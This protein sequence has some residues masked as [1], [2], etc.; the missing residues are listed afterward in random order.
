MITRKN[1]ETYVLDYLEGT[2]SEDL[3]KAFENFL[4]Q[5]PD[6]REEIESLC[7]MPSITPQQESFPG[8]HRLKASTIKGLTYTEELIIAEL[9]N[10]AT[11]E[12]RQELKYIINN[13]PQIKNL[14]LEYQHTKL[15]PPDITYPYK[16]YLKHKVISLPVIIKNAV[17]YAALVILLIAIT[18][19][20]RHP[21]RQI[22][23]SL[24]LRPGIEQTFLLT[25]ADLAPMPRLN[26]PVIVKHNKQNTSHHSNKQTVTT[27][28]DTISSPQQT[29]QIVDRIKPKSFSVQVP[30]THTI[31]IH[32]NQ[33][34]T[35]FYHT[36]ADLG[37]KTK[38][39]FST[40]L[41]ERGIKITRREFMI[42]IKNR[43][44]GI[45]VAG[46]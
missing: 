12:Q 28:R 43:S 27:T 32:N 18:T 42:K 34:K 11:P 40:W 23:T 39:K 38:K 22:A 37:T 31:I 15:Q 14:R 6:I 17:A 13:D 5:N 8:K 35:K 45:S 25:P 10:I 30:I 1:Y 21:D 41:E 7:D 29:A 44:Y 33:E 24:E 16:N 4:N 9:E 20:L 46:K 3:K 26:R 19:F 2:L 36:L